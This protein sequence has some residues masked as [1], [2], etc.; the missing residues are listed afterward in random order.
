MKNRIANI[1]FLLLIQIIICMVI[2]GCQ[3]E[4]DSLPPPP[5]ESVTFIFKNTGDT[6]IHW[7]KV[8]YEELERFKS[9]PKESEVIPGCDSRIQILIIQPDKCKK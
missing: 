5:C 8:C 2:F 4:G 7:H 1:L 9:Y 6:I 3:K